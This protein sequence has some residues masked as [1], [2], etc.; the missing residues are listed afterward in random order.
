MPYL[1]DGLSLGCIYAF[2]ALGYTMVYG[3]IKLINFAHGE[4]FMVGAFL[5][6]LSLQNLGVER[7][8]LPHPI[9]V[10]L[11]WGVA[12]LLAAL[13]SAALAVVI[14]RVAYKPLRA[15][16]DRITALVAALGVSLFLQNAMVHV[17]SAG[18]QAFPEPRMFTSATALT[19]A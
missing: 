12:L 2:I 4:V 13:G 8:P 9:P 14:D 17:F 18:Q 15:R 6:M 1:L 5:A 16:A 10:L 7:L 19:P 3:I 11:A